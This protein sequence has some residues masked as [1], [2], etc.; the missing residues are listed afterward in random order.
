MVLEG[1]RDQATQDKFIG[2]WWSRDSGISIELMPSKETPRRIKGITGPLAGALS[3]D[4]TP[5]VAAEAQVARGATGG[6]SGRRPRHSAS[7]AYRASAVWQSL[8]GRPF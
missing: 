3:P 4:I 2:P 5:R 8:L 6:K 1:K 7:A